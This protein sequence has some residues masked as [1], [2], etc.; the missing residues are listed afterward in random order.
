MMT[1]CDDSTR[2]W[3]TS[4]FM[5]R[6][7][8]ASILPLSLLRVC[9]VYLALLCAVAIVPFH[10]LITNFSDATFHWLLAYYRPSRA[11]VIAAVQKQT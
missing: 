3:L 6:L 2:E 9:T 5:M 10:H 1:V 11:R 7:G 4:G 8:S